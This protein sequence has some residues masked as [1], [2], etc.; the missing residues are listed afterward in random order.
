MNLHLLIKKNYILT[1]TLP[2][3]Q[4]HFLYKEWAIQLVIPIQIHN[5]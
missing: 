5:G 4:V 3:P 1:R 2:V